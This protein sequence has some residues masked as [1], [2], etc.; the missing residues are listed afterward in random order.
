VE[1]L[2]LYFLWSGLVASAVS[3][4]LYLMYAFQPQAVA[5]LAHVLPSLG[6]PALST[7][8]SGAGNVT[9]TTP[10]A[11]PRMQRSGTLAGV[12]SLSAWVTVTFGGL[13][14]VFRTIALE[15]APF[16]NLFEFSMAFGF[17]I[18]LAYALSERRFGG[19]LLGAFV[20]PVSFALYAS[21]IA[22]P[23]EG[24]RVLV[25]ALQSPTL[26]SI[27]VALMILSYAVLAVAF[28]AALMHL[29]QGDKGRRHLWLPSAR[30]CDELTY[31]SVLV[32]FPLLAVGVALGAFWANDAWGRYWGWDPK[33]TAALVTWLIFAAYLHTRGV[34]QFRGARGAWIVVGG[35][36]GVL[37]TY[38]A[39]NLWITGLHSYAGV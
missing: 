3:S 25:P 36:I 31:R 17:A 33:E 32:G 26:L 8:A 22:F 11:A 16:S 7:A 15:H 19:H 5:L 6:R 28:G 21:A 9:L 29:L 13:G 2:A 12:A 37:F 27:H 35:F 23:S 10:D 14:L 39:V 4:A 30:R 1:D 24:E 20:M 38:L 18:A 34:R